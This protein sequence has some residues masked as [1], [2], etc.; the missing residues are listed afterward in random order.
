MFI[1]LFEQWVSEKTKDAK[2]SISIKSNEA[3]D[4]NVIA[5]DDNGI[6]SQFSK[7]YRVISSS[8]PKIKEG[9]SIVVSSA[10]DKEGDYEVVVV[11]DPQVGE[12]IMNYTGAVEITQV[13]DL[14]DDK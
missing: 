9:A 14:P 11:N 5:I 10:V 13:T 7:S 2:L 12:D 3:G 4:F 1:K 6:E 8:N